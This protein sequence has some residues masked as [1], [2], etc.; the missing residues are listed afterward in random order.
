M[1]DSFHWHG[2]HTTNCYF[3]YLSIYSTIDIYTVPV[4]HWKFKFKTISMLY[5]AL[6]L[7]NSFHCHSLQSLNINL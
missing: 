2:L 7:L 5:P 1:L 6:K 3:K 4:Q